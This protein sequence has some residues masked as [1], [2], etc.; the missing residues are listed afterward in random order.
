MFR[1]T[2]ANPAQKRTLRPLYAQHQA[3]PWT[4]FLDPSWD[5][6]FDIYPGSVMVR[7]TKELF[8]PYTAAANSKPFG[9]SAFFVAPVL[10]IDE[11]TNTATN[12]F[13]VWVGDGQALFEILAP[14]FDATATWTLTTDGS[15]QLL[16]ATNKGLIT[17][18][19]A[20]AA[21]AIAELVDVPSPDKIVV[22]LNRVA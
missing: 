19:G 21:N 6:S 3:T 14:A 1:P 2:L 16:T 8:L 20:T 17:L 15:R 5:K 4:G 12:L 7:T 13:T 22:R 18:T 10:G 11:V 9:L